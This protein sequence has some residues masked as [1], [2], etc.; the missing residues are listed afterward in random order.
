MKLAERF[1]SYPPF[2]NFVQLLLGMD[3]YE[4]AAG[5]IKKYP[6]KSVL[7]IGCGTGEL[8]KEITFKS[9]LGIDI[10]EKYINYAVQKYAKGNIQF[11][12]DD[13]TKMGRLN[14]HFSL[15]LV[16]NVIHHFSPTKLNLTLRN[17][18]ANISFDKIMVIDSQPDFGIFTSL[19][20]KGDLGSYFRELKT[21][22][23]YIE[24]YFEIQDAKVL[25]K[26]YWP[27]KYPLVV[28]KKRL[29][30]KS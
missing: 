26:F 27:Y 24:K 3:F 2:Y 9:Y 5:E 22:V 20:E 11:L 17:I 8:L 28:G 7:E 1:L 29:F 12:V 10:N 30:P 23:G 16:I 14:E 25:S 6:H 4:V 13:V 15:V 18:S 19:L 21:I